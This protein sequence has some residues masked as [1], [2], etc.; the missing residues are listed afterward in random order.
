MIFFRNILISRTH[1]FLSIFQMMIL[2]MALLFSSCNTSEVIPEDQE[3]FIKLYGGNGS[4]EGYDILQLDDEG[5]ILV[6][7]TTSNTLGDKDVLVIRTDKDGNELWKSHVGR[8][9]NDIGRSV[10]LGNNGSLYICGE[11]VQSAL[12]VTGFRD[13][14]VLNV[15]TADG[16]LIS[17]RVFGDSLRDE[18]GTDIINS[19]NN[20][21]LITSTRVYTDSTVFYMIETDQSLN[22]IQERIARK[23]GSDSFSSTSAVSTSSDV[24]LNPYYCFGTVFESVLGVNKFLSF[25]FRTTGDQAIDPEVY[26]FNTGDSFCTDVIQSTDN[27]F[28]MCGYFQEGNVSEEM[29]VK[30]NDRRQ[31]I[32]TKTYPNEYNRS[33][34]DAGIFQTADGG[35]VVTSVIQLDDPKNDEISLLRLDAAGDVVWRNTFG[36]DEDDRGAGVIEM[37]DGGFAIVGTVGFEINTNSQSKLCLIK[38]NKDG[39]LITSK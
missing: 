11:S 27:G 6:G 28:Y 9:G 15:S 21:F 37:N 25:K 13:V 23:R 1:G 26:G 35:F 30:I 14:Y 39:N 18:F 10:I 17:E 32:W 7:S 20:G 34:G 38:V 33:V 16:N 3:V 22:P 31:E 12:P 29:V 19:V 36:S 5:F 2:G 24:S 4:D 8:Q